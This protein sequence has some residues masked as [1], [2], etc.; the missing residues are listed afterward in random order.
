MDRSSTVVRTHLSY[1]PG[2][3]GDDSRC[4]VCMERESA[5]G[6]DGAC[7]PIAVRECLDGARQA[8]HDL[9]GPPPSDGEYGGTCPRCGASEVDWDESSAGQEEQ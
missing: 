7:S 3:E 6:D 4:E 1:E 8:A 9:E 2:E 5:H